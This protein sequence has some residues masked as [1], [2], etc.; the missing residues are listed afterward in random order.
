MLIIVLNKSSKLLEI[1]S[2]L[3]A[4]PMRFSGVIIYLELAKHVVKRHQLVQ[5]INNEHVIE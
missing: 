2:T 4:Q 5:I 3:P 1:V